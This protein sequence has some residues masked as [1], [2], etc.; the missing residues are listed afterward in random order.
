MHIPYY[1]AYFTP[2]KWKF[3]TRTPGDVCKD[4]QSSIAKAKTNTNQNKTQKQPKCLLTI[5]C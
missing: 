4:V 5:G 2:V 3:C 1:K